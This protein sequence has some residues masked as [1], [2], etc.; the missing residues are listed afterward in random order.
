MKKLGFQNQKLKSNKTTKQKLNHI[1]RSLQIQSGEYAVC[2]GCG[3]R[4]E[5]S[6]QKRN[7][8]RKNRFLEARVQE[9]HR[10]VLEQVLISEPN[11]TLP[12]FKAH[13]V[14]SVLRK[15]SQ[16]DLVLHGYT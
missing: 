4:T 14:N 15:L 9:P 8:W 16:K 10:D 12:S 1:R 3:T 11:G 7:S 6:T 2:F 5:T 13:P